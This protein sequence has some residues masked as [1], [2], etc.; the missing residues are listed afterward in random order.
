M[1]GT[2]GIT[3]TTYEFEILFIVILVFFNALKNISGF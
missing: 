1:L 2:L 3:V